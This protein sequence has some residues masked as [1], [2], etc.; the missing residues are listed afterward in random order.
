MRK[1]VTKN[2][3][4]QLKKKLVGQSEIFSFLFS[5]TH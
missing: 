1:V 5:R 4:E 2:T 3:D